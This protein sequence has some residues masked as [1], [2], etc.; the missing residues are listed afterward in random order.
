MSPLNWTPRKQWA[1]IDRRDNFGIDVVI[2]KSA[3]GFTWW[4]DVLDRGLG[5]THAEYS[6][7]PPAR[8]LVEAKRRAAQQVDA[9]IDRL[10]RARGGA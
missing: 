7:Q 3:A 6:A 10:T 2:D 8:S 4:I 9:L 5:Q 1:A